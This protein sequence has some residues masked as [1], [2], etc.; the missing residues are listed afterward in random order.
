MKDIPVPD[1]VTLATLLASVADLD[2]VITRVKPGPNG[3]ALV[4]FEK[5]IQ[6]ERLKIALPGQPEEIGDRN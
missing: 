2:Y 1:R 3:V 6:I 5:R 4:T